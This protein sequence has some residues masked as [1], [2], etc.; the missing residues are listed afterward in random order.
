MFQPL[1]EREMQQ[2]YDDWTIFSSHGMVLFHFAANPN[3]TQRQL[4]HL[5]GLTERQIGRIVKDLAGADILYVQRVG[6]RNT[7]I[8]NPQAHLRH[9]T[10]A[11]IP[12]QRIIAA[13][14]PELKQHVEV[15][16]GT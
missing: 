5:L 10:L 4:S 15:S 3:S 2:R 6:R 16:V 11:H 13:V 7:Y 12:L 14:V 9:P 1:L 8:V